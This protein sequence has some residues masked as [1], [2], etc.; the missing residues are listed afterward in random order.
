MKKNSNTSKPVKKTVAN[1]TKEKF[2]ETL[3]VDEL[4]E[5]I[6]ECENK[7]HASFKGESCKNIMNAYYEWQNAK[8]RYYVAIGVCRPPEETSMDNFIE[9]EENDTLDCDFNSLI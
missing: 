8:K 1:K 5:Y 3:S 4:K 2:V 6:R 9:E 7:Y